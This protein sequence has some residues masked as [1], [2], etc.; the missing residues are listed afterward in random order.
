MTSPGPPREVVRVRDLR[1]PALDLRH[2]AVEVVGAL[3]VDRAARVAADDVVHAGLA[4]DLR[5][6]DAG[7]A[8]ADDEDAQV[9]DPLAGELQRVEDRGE[10]DD[11]GA[12]LVVVE[13]GDV[14]LGLQ[15]VL[16]LEAARRRDVLEVDAAERRGD[17]LD[18]LDDLVGVLGVEADRERVDAGELLE[19]D[20]LALHDRHRGLG[21][22]VAQAE[23]RGAVAD[24]GDGVA[25][26]RELEGLLAVGGDRRAHAGDAR[27][28]GHREVVAVA[29]RDLVALLDLA[30]QV[31]QERPVAGVEH[32]R[33]RRRGRRRGSRPSAPGRARRR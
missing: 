32:L 1:V 17:P 3:G 29:D 26:D 30:A 20:R 7:G 24:D 8:E 16:D 5:H 19:Q 23:H 31:G 9:L 4:Q 28:V 6:R 21:A 11:R 14:E 27:R 22:D 10:H 13:D 15:P 12:V 25:L 2:R 33:A 18:G